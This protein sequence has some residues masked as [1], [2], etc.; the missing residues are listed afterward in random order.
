MTTPTGLSTL[1]EGGG[2]A[3]PLLSFADSL[4]AAVNLARKSRNKSSLEMMKPFQGTVAASDFNSILGNLNAAS[5]KTSTNLLKRVADTQ[6]LLSVNEAQTLGLPY[7][8]TKADAASR[9]I[10]PKKE[11][12]NL[13]IRSGNLEYTRE[14]YSEDASTLEQSRGTDGY[15]NSDLY[16]KLYDVWVAND[17]K[18][19][20]FIKTYPPDQYVNPADDW[21]PVYLQ[22][23]K[24][25]VTNPFAQ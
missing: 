12:A 15:V 13:L 22:P 3:S 19:A 23:K 14:D 20:D 18:I 6:E 11:T 16:K 17:G 10:I 4:D 9:G 2:A 25:G 1:P 7:G 21:L 5:D 8:T 24:K